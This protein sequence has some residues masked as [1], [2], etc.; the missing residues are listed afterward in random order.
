MPVPAR[1]NEQRCPV[2]AHAGFRFDARIAQPRTRIY[3]QEPQKGASVCAGFR[4]LSLTFLSLCLSW[5]L[6]TS[7]AVSGFAFIKAR[8]SSACPYVICTTALLSWA[9]S[10]PSRQHGV[11]GPGGRAGDLGSQSFPVRSI[12]C[13]G[14]VSRF[15]P[16]NDGR[17]HTGPPQPRRNVVDFVSLSACI[18]TGFPSCARLRVLSSVA[19]VL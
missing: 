17:E 13:A 9:V 1:S 12:P 6:A 2:V 19:G 11:L 14:R 3:R 7:A 18:F 15:F 16:G 10:L 4:L 8:R 5:A